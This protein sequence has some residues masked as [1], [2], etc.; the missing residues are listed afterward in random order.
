M[1]SPLFF[2][3][4]GN[5]AYR[6]VEYDK[7]L[8]F[9]VLYAGFAFISSLIREAIKDMEDM[10]GDAKYGCRTLPIVGGIN[11]AKTYVVVWMV[12]LIGVLLIVQFYALQFHWWIAVIYSFVFLILPLL[13]AFRQMFR[14][15]TPAEFNRLSSITKLVMMMGILS[16]VF[17]KIYL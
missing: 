3:V 7:I 14:V 8:R 4:Y 9:T 6:A 16:M 11:A 12:V 13:Y 2:I 15:K 17:F 1:G 10:S 5:E